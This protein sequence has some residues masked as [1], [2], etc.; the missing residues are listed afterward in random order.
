MINI[1][2]IRFEI[3][4]FYGPSY[5][6]WGKRRKFEG[7]KGKQRLKKAKKGGLGRHHISEGLCFGWC[8]W[9]KGWVTCCLACLLGYV[10][11]WDDETSLISDVSL[12]GRIRCFCWTHPWMVDW[13]ESKFLRAI[14]SFSFLFFSSFP[15][16]L[17]FVF[18]RIF[19]GIK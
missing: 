16:L 4:N 14:S 18:L 19:I 9:G 15:F 17:S 8:N 3:W 10:S 7:K 12:K 11:M 5:L 1:N 13:L 2:I 6:F